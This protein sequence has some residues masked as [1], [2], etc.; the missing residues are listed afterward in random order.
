VTKVDILLNY[1]GVV[2]DRGDL[3]AKENGKSCAGAPFLGFRIF[4][5]AAI[6]EDRDNRA[7]SRG[8]VGVSNM[9]PR[10]PRVPGEIHLYICS[11]QGDRGYGGD[12][13]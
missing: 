12:V 4:Y 6:G 13:I 3:R 10:Y 1:R 8:R 9:Q 2:S 7:S 5:L 11:E